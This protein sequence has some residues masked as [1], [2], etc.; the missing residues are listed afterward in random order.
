MFAIFGPALGLYV[1]VCL[2]MGYPTIILR[3]VAKSCTTKRSKG[4]LKP[5]PN[6]MGCF[7]TTVFWISLPHPQ[8]IKVMRSYFHM[9]NILSVYITIYIH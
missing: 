1:W 8:Y 4:W 5:K 3:M 6:F 7:K 9:Y 2:K